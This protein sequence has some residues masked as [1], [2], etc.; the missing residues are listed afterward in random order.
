MTST[1]LSSLGKPEQAAPGDTASLRW[2]SFS[3]QLHQTSAWSFFSSR[4]RPLSKHLHMDRVGYQRQVTRS[5]TVQQQISDTAACLSHNQPQSH[6]K[7]EALPGRI[8]SRNPRLQGEANLLPQK[9][10]SFPLQAFTLILPELLPG[11]DYWEV[12]CRTSSLCFAQ[13]LH[14]NQPGLAS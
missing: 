7:P 3:K 13:H 8:P 4:I 12:L 11:Q 10:T 5:L 9:K 6:R 14:A 1:W 2:W